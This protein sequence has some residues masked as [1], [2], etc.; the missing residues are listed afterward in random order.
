MCYM[1]ALFVYYSCT[2]GRCESYAL[3][4]YYLCS[5]SASRCKMC[6]LSVYYLCV[7]GWVGVKSVHPLCIICVLLLWV[8]IIPCTG[9]GT[10]L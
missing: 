4:V 7:A 6:A 3:S 5:A 10:F 1:R 8:V 2:V 9:P